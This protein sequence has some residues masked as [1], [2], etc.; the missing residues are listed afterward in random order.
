M[1]LFHKHLLHPHLMAHMAGRH[2]LALK[3][4]RSSSDASQF[5]CMHFF[6]YLLISV[7][8]VGREATSVSLAVN[9]QCKLYMSGMN[10]E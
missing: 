9:T 2:S 8:S 10:P 1:P 5:E 3:R 7:R 4:E 6:L